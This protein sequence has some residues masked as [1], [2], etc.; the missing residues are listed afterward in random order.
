MI[1]QAP[2]NKIV[3]EV[4]K[5]LLGEYLLCNEN[6]ALRML[7]FKR[8][9]ISFET[10]KELNS[11]ILE[12]ESFRSSTC[13][14]LLSWMALLS[15]RASTTGHSFKET[16]DQAKATTLTRSLFSKCLKLEPIFNK[17]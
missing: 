15:S 3:M 14:G 5:D 1:S 4:N 6:D 17:L 11:Q 7:F 9:R 8:I 13:V 12:I 2:L 16:C 10:Y